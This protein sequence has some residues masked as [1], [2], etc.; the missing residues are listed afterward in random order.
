MVMHNKIF[1]ISGRMSGYQPVWVGKLGSEDLL[2][3]VSNKR[4]FMD[5]SGN[6]R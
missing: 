3:A 5:Q 6:G 4:Y 1:R 2:S